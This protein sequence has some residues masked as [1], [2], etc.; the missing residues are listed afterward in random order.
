MQAGALQLASKQHSQQLNARSIDAVRDRL[1]I[2]RQAA[3]KLMTAAREL[4]AV[5]P[6]QAGLVGWW[7][8]GWVPHRES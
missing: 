7:R 8:G 4:T 3:M 5:L 6:P 1:P 2:S